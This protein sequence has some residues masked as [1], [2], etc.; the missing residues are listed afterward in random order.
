MTDKDKKVI[1]TGG[2]FY[3]TYWETLKIFF[4]WHLAQRERKSSKSYSKD[5]GMKEETL[6]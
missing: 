3:K 5:E 6:N 2:N 1:L 4:K